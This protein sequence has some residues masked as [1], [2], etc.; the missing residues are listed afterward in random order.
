MKSFKLLAFSALSIL[1]LLNS[2]S[3][4]KRVHMPGYH[5]E[6]HHSKGHVSENKIKTEDPI[7]A[8][9]QQELVFQ[10]VDQTEELVVLS[11]NE[12]ENVSPSIE[13]N[14]TA[15]TTLPEKIYSIECDNI[16]L[17]N[18]STISAKVTE[19]RDEEIKYK[20]CENLNGPTYSID[21]SEVSGIKYANGTQDTFSTGNNNPSNVPPISNN[22]KATI[23][24]FAIAAMLAAIIGIFLYVATFG[25]VAIILSIISL[26]RIKKNP[27]RFKGK[28]LAITALVLGILEL[29]LAILVIGILLGILIA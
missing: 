26:S 23:E 15:S 1:I 13:K 27:N 19:I 18:G 28:G 14:V 12:T 3:I 25:T 6:W 17:R 8:E 9:E 20:K 5:V 22:S 24:G 29:L 11:S 4:E 7:I 2:C 10:E 21:K 16:I